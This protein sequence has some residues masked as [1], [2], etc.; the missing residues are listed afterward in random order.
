MDRKKKKQKPQN[1]TS[2]TQQQHLFFF[3]NFLPTFFSGVCPLLRMSS[4]SSHAKLLHTL[5]Q[6]VL[7]TLACCESALKD[8]HHAELMRWNVATD[9]LECRRKA[10]L[11]DAEIQLRKL[12]VSIA[13]I[14]TEDTAE[15]DIQLITRYSNTLTKIRRLLHP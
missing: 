2:F 4:S 9:K 5:H 13:N 1:K 12:L 6:E 7:Q 11:L 8:V 3:F 10:N 14:D 15:C